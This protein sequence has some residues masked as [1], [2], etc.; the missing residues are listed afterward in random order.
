MSD[1][2]LARLDTYHA[3]Q[4]LG[5]LYRQVERLP[6]GI[7][8]VV[9]RS[10]NR[11]ILSMRTVTSKMIRAEYAALKQDVDE[12]MW[13]K[14]ATLHYK[15]AILYARGR[16]SIPLVRWKATQT[17]KGVSVLIRKG[18]GKKVI[19]A[20]GGKK[21]APLFGTFIA[22][23][24][25][26]GRIKQKSRYPIVR[27]YGPSFLAILGRPQTRAAQQERATEIFTKRVL[28]EA[29]NLLSRVKA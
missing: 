4:A 21:N 25:V 28:V 9:V 17:R 14:Q 23:G 6:N 3:Q 8:R 22:K 16:M 18:G 5:D 20:T 11:A 10:L 13:V 1:K 19:A 29:K 15:V 27:L 12:T 26:Y 24:E 2:R 7:E